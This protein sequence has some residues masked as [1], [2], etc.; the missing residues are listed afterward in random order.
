MA[1]S[2][3]SE[4]RRFTCAGCVASVQWSPRGSLS[5]WGGPVDPYFGLPLWLRT[6]VRRGRMLWA[7]N[8]AHLDLLEGYVAAGVRERDVPASGLTMV[9]RLPLWVKAA[10]NRGEVLRSVAR[11]RE[12]VDA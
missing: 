7:F 8:V 10:G 9:A 5:C 12:L 3:L 2:P 4:P 1:G 11:L 6:S